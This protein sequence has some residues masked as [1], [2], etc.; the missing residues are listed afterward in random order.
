MPAASASVRN[1]SMR[2]EYCRIPSDTCSTCEGK[3][4]H[5]ATTIAQPYGVGGGI[6]HLI[7]ATALRTV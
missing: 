6:G 7:A 1:S 2:G 4:K 3:S 5:C